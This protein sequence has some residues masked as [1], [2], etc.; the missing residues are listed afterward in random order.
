M[1]T[2][3]EQ[4]DVRRFMGYSVSGDSTSF[5]FRELV[6]S[7][8]SYMGLS[9]DYRLQHLM[10]EE[11]SVVRAVYLVRLNS[12]ETAI[13]DSSDNLDTDAA[14]VWTHNKNEVQD[15]TELFNQWR[16]QLCSFLGFN[17]GPS[18]GDGGMTVSRC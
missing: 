17:P 6:Y 5:P 8:V 12:L 4:V 14:A 18:L 16:R 11:E 13:T 2:S 15:R 10:P 1:L 9:I 3:A 7:D